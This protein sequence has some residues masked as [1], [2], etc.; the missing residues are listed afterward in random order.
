MKL[1]L[2]VTESASKMFEFQKGEQKWS[3]ESLS[4]CDV[5]IQIKLH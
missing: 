5:I 1:E 2:T 3:L 4:R